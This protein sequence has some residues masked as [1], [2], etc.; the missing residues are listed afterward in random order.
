MHYLRRQLAIDDFDASAVHI[1]CKDESDNTVGDDVNKR[2]TYM[3]CT[4]S[5][6][7]RQYPTSK[8]DQD[9]AR[10][11]FNAWVEAQPTEVIESSNEVNNLTDFK[12]EEVHT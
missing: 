7:V 5:E 12:P 10:T 4:E 2:A 6:F 9:L 1:K 8:E 11:A 3:V